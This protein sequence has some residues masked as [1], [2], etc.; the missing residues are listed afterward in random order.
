[1][2]NTEN[3]TDQTPTIGAEQITLLEH[4]SNA[5]AVSGNESEV[6]AIVLEQIKPFA[7]DIKIDAMGNVLAT[8]QAQVERPLRVMLAAHMDEVGLMLVEED[9]GGLYR[10]GVIGGIDARQ[11]PGKPVWVGKSHLPGI[12]GAKAI[13]LTTPEER[14]NTIPV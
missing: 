10:F 9:E 3:L 1:M 11:L 5:C 14:R 6:R 8:C 7:S 2:S 4:L 12:I 13:H